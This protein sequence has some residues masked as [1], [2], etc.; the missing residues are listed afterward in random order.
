MRLWLTATL[1]AWL[2]VPSWAGDKDS[3]PPGGVGGA[4]AEVGFREGM[5]MICPVSKKLALTAWHVAVREKFLRDEPRMLTMSLDDK[6]VT[7]LVVMADLRR[8]LAV[9]MIAAGEEFPASLVHS[10][11]KSRPSLGDKVWVLNSGLPLKTKII[12]MSAGYVEYEKSPGPGSSGGCVLNDQ[13]EVIVINT[14][15]RQK[16]FGGPAGGGW[17]VW[18]PWAE[19]PDDFAETAKHSGGVGGPEG[20]P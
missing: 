12:H 19:I 4:G 14:Y 5:G 7:L 1:V 2:V 10:I 16:L 18:G 3:G 6:P 9:V 8:D 20:Q 11:A 17:A 13:G 15:M